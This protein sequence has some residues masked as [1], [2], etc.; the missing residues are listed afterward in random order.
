MVGEAGVEHLTAAAAQ[1]AMRRVAG[2]L[3]ARGVVDGDRVAFAL[4]NS[5]G[6]LA[7]LVGTM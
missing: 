4:P 5:A 3:R 6:L 7:A 1:A 2:G